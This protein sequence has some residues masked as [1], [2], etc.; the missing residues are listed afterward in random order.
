M[1]WTIFFVSISVFCWVNASV[2]V[3]FRVFED[4]AAEFLSIFEEQV[5]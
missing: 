2:I 1:C 3:D 4:V 5:G